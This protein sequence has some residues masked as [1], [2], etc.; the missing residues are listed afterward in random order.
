MG[1]AKRSVLSLHRKAAKD[2]ARTAAANAPGG[3]YYRPTVAD[4]AR[5]AADQARVKV[6]RF[7]D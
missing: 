4:Q 5:L 6:R 2:A 3:R 1:R 7:T